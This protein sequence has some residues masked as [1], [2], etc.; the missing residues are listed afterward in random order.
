MTDLAEL[1]DAAEALARGYLAK[2]DEVGPAVLVQF[3]SGETGLL[4]LEWGNDQ[5][6][7]LRLAALRLLFRETGVTAYA[8]WSECWMASHVVKA[9]EPPPDPAKWKG[10]MP[11]DNPERVDALILIG[12]EKGRP[13]V[14]RSYRKVKR[15][16]GATLEPLLDGP[17]RAAGRLTD[18][19]A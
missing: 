12:A 3:P 14:I 18:L 13:A 6:K 17:D 5:D 11:R 2:V 1:M 16:G 4:A 19:L 10:V 9:G 8:L 7:A 15:A